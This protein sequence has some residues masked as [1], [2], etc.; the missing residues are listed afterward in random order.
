MSQEGE[1]LHSLA[2]SLSFA[3]RA[4]SSLNVNDFACS[5]TL[6]GR[7]GREGPRWEPVYLFELRLRCPT[8]NVF[9]GEL[10][11]VR[12]NKSCHPFHLFRPSQGASQTLGGTPQT[13][14]GTPA[15]QPSRTLP[16]CF[17]A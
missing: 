11:S 9:V 4:A 8:L 10:F 1:I 12:S 15:T 14:R 6:T 13:L 16:Y 2:A 5:P 17:T 3:R 7:P